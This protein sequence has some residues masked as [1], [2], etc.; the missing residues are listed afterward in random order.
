MRPTLLLSISLGFLT[1]HS[2]F[3]RLG[4]TQDQAEARYG[5]PK[6]EK[7]AKYGTPLIE[8]AKE[9][10]FEYEGWRIRCALLRA[11]DGKEYIMRE[12]YRKVWNSEVVKKGGIINI[13]DFERDAVLKGEAGNSQWTK[14]VLGDLNRNPLQALSNQLVHLSGLA[15]T[16][17]TRDDGAVARFDSTSLILDLPQARKYE[18]E[19]KAIKEKKAREKVPKF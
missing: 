11:T 13:R 19:L 7:V 15:G 6:S 8:G 12:E 3:A 2:T 4:E 16:V 5:L 1:L 9:L 18:A 10:T 14:K 17:W